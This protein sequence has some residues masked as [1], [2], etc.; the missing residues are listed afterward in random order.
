MVL[1]AETK[2]DAKVNTNEKVAVKVDNA[3]EVYIAEVT[4]IYNKTGADG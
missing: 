1:V 3:E 2:K 4:N